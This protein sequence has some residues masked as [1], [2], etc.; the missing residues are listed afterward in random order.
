MCVGAPLRV[1]KLI[2]AKEGGD[3]TWLVTEEKMLK[4]AP[5]SPEEK[6]LKTTQRPPPDVTLLWRTGRIESS[7]NA[8]VGKFSCIPL[9]DI[10]AE[11]FPNQRS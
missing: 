2:Y 8:F 6:M 11:L 5:A 1:I 7:L 3:T 10:L 9:F 4:R